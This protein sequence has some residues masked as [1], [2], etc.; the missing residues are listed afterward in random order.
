M[1]WIQP[2][3]ARDCWIN[4]EQCLSVSHDTFAIYF[5]FSDTTRQFSFNTKEEA[6]DAWETVRRL[7][8]YLEHQMVREQSYRGSLNNGKP[9][10]MTP[11]PVRNE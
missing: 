10:V 4:I 11:L 1:K 2:D 9:V 3:P 8:G 5:E 6:A 7:L